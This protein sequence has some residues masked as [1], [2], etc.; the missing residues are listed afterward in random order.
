MLSSV[1]IITVCSQPRLNLPR[2]AQNSQRE[3]A[4]RMSSTCARGNASAPPFRL[5]PSSAS[6]ACMRTWA[7][8]PAQSPLYGSVIHCI[9]T[10]C[11]LECTVHFVSMLQQQCSEGVQKAPGCQKSSRGSQCCWQSPKAG[12]T[13]STRGTH[14]HSRAP[15]QPLPIGYGQ[16]CS[17][18]SSSVSTKCYWIKGIL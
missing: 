5:L 8:K 16:R 10:Q 9:P 18:Y 2:L 14:G 7:F 11:N 6:P 3:C 4:Q 15:S 17:S 1:F 12:S 13:R